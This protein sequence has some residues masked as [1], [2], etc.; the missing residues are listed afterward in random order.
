[1]I[2]I[3]NAFMLGVAGFFWNRQGAMNMIIIMTMIAL[4]VINAAA[5]S[6]IIIN[7][8]DRP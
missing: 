7:W 6:V 1:M 4:A 3:A 5:A 8:M 2:F